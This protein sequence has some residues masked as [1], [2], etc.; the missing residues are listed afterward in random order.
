LTREEK[1]KKREAA[2]LGLTVPSSKRKHPSSSMQSQHSMKNGRDS[3][4]GELLKLGTNRS[5]SQLESDLNATR[6]K[7][8]ALKGQGAQ[9]DRIGEEER[10][11][12]ELEVMLRR[13][14]AM[15]EKRRAEKGSGMIPETSIRLQE[16][17][18]SDDWKRERKMASK[19]GH[20][21]AARNPFGLFQERLSRLVS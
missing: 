12:R 11:E 21:T 10:K 8:I 13:E 4:V 9:R 2:M 14:K 6:R 15:E 17:D 3:P 5:I 18:M 7:Q 20:A 19:A 16:A 1:K